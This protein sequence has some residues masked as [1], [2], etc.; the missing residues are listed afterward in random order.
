MWHVKEHHTLNLTNNKL[1]DPFEADL[2]KLIRKIRFRNDQNHFQTK[3]NKDRKELKNSKCIWVRADKLRN[4]YKI[5][6]SNYHKILRNEMTDTYRM[7][8]NDSISQINNDTLKFAHKLHIE[9]RF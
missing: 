2:F 9:D 5:N 4:I 1:L 8:Y 3:L 6:P 7:D